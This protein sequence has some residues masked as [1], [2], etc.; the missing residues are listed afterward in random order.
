MSVSMLF[1]FCG[2][3]YAEGSQE[4]IERIDEEFATKTWASREDWLYDANQTVATIMTNKNSAIE[5]FNQGNFGMANWYIP[6]FDAGCYRYQK[7]LEAG[8]ANR[9]IKRNVMEEQKQKLLAYREEVNAAIR[10]ASGGLG[11]E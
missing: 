3:V 10:R 2:T 5:Y 11:L 8:V 4:K 9:Y 1:L 7:I 6:D